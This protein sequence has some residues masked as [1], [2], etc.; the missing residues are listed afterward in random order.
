MLSY[1]FPMIFL[2]QILL[3]Q[4][5]DSFLCKPEALWI[6]NIFQ[7]AEHI[8]PK[9][10]A[11]QLSELFESFQNGES[12]IPDILQYFFGHLRTSKNRQKMGPRTPYLLRKYS[13]ESKTI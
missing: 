8:G 13:T 12:M 4:T 6:L 9:S 5:D 2:N 11:K 3:L 7:K 1:D 10:G